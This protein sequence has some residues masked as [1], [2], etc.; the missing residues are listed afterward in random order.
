VAPVFYRRATHN[1]I[2]WVLEICNH[3]L[4]SDLNRWDCFC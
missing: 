4:V 2:G 1:L 3:E